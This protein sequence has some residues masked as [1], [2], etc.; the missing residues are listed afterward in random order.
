VGSWGVRVHWLV[1]R[2]GEEVK[3][4]FPS[5]D[6]PSDI[7]AIRRIHNDDENA[8]ARACFI[9]V[10]QPDPTEKRGDLVFDIFRMSPESYLW[11]FGRVYTPPRSRRD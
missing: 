3:A 1:W 6:G 4:R 7:G 11:H 8:R 2:A 5:V 9:A 10:R